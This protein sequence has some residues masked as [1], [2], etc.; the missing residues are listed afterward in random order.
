MDNCDL[1]FIAEQ[2]LLWIKRDGSEV[3]LHARIGAPYPAEGG[4]W[5]CPAE[6]I[7]LDGRYPDIVGESSMQA[8][9][10]AI[11]LIGRRLGHLI[12]SGE[13]LAYPTELTDRLDAEWLTANFGP[14]GESHDF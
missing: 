9:S 6:L 7:G 3:S 8:L 11:R 10:L 4:V 5:A 1:P 13:H 12:H 14:I 2:E